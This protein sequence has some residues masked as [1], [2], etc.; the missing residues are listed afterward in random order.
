MCGD[1]WPRPL[2][3]RLICRAMVDQGA[4]AVGVGQQRAVRHLCLPFAFDRTST[5]TKLSRNPPRREKP[6]T[7]RN[8]CRRRSAPGLCCRRSQSVNGEPQAYACKH[9]RRDR[10][11]LDGNRHGRDPTIAKIP[12]V[13]RDRRCAASRCSV[14]ASEGLGRTLSRLAVNALQ[15][16]DCLLAQAL[17]LELTRAR[18]RA[19]PAVERRCAAKG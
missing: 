4:S 10:G 12:N 2:S 8:F 3:E 13:Y 15:R 16:L 5:T 11:E 19:Q 6:R 1:S 9:H 7:R 14:R 18:R 17:T